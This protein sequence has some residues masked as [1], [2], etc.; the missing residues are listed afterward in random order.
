[1]TVAAQSSQ[2]KSLS[3]EEKL[4]KSNKVEPKKLFNEATKII[5][6]PGSILSIPLP[7]N[8]RIKS[9]GLFTGK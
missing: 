8:N 1:V 5:R 9:A 7:A 6:P 2:E 3:S 4:R